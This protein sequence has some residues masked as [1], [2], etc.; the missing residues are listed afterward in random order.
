MAFLWS[1]KT[2]YA[3]IIDPNQI[4][5]MSTFVFRY[6]DCHCFSCYCGQKISLAP[7]MLPNIRFSISNFTFKMH[8]F[9]YQNAISIFDIRIFIVFHGIISSKNLW[10]QK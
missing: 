3:N 2:T 7:G 6:Q 8:D 10:H 1:D 5:K 4:H 9:E